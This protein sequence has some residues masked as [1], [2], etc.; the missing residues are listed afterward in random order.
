MAKSREEVLSEGETTPQFLDDAERAEFAQALLGDEAVR[1]LES[2]LGQLLRGYADQE[3]EEVKDE[4][5]RTPSWRK[6]KINKLQFRGAVAEQFIRF[7]QEAILNGQVSEQN[8][9]QMREQS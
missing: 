4:L 2:D 7:V 6:R 3:L 9:K 8:L 1:F 5:L